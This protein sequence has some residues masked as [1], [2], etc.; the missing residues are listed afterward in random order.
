MT[1]EGYCPLQP[2][3]PVMIDN[4]DEEDGAGGEADH[5]VASLHDTT[6]Q[7]ITDLA[8]NTSEFRVPLSLPNIGHAPGSTP[9]WTS[10]TRRSRR[11]ERTLQW[12][13]VLR[14]LQTLVPP[15]S[16]QHL[17]DQLLRR[18]LRNWEMARNL[19]LTIRRIDA[20]ASLP[21]YHHNYFL[22]PTTTYT[23]N[24]T[25]V[26]RHPTLR[27]T[28]DF[29]DVPISGIPEL[30]WCVGR[31]WGAISVQSYTLS[32]SNLTLTVV[33]NGLLHWQIC[34]IE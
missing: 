22:G 7:H 12:M 28:V 14:G 18:E 25:V 24:F 20:I 26:L 17:V 33:Y 16:S 11:T 6:S 10:N 19:I 4:D 3:D 29:E 5:L 8:I 23:Q 30:I 32:C 15:L 2:A 1:I 34:G 13:R 31:W 27:L 9:A 21:P